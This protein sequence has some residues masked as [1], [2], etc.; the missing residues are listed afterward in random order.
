MIS[1]K[2]IKEDPAL[3]IYWAEAM[4]FPANISQSLKDSKEDEFIYNYLRAELNGLD[5][6]NYKE[7]FFYLMQNKYNF[8]KED[9]EKRLENIKKMKSVFI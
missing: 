5:N 2:K 8:K 7:D 4:L 1:Q 6:I 9:L 3:L